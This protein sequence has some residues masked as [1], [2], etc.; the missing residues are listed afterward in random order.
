[1]TF[2]PRMGS[3][4]QLGPSSSRPTTPKPSAVHSR[5]TTPTILAGSTPLNAHVA[6]RNWQGDQDEYVVTPFVLE[7]AP[8]SALSPHTTVNGFPLEKGAGRLV[9]QNEH[10]MDSPYSPAPSPFSAALSPMSAGTSA[11][12]SVESSPF[13]AARSPRPFVAE[14]KHR[15][16]RR[17]RSR[18]AS[19]SRDGHTTPVA[20][21]T[22]DL[23]PGAPSFLQSD[24]TE[25]GRDGRSDP[26]QRPGYDPK[27]GTVLPTYGA[28]V[29]DSPSA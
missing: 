6:P 9:S 4:T 5:P 24:P 1:M 10:D 12:Y 14:E 7:P 26:T 27:R 25:Q 16:R 18:S 21:P 20:P 8:A 19:R 2:L 22:L 28:A 3:S 11:Y 23:D 15:P 29:R 17:S 13:S